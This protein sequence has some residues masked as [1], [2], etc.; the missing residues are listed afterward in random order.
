LQAPEATEGWVIIV[1][2]A[3]VGIVINTLTALLFMR[4][5]QEDLNIRG[6]FLHMAADA[7][8][9]LGVVIGG[10]LYVCRSAA[11]FR[12]EPSVERRLCQM[13][14]RQQLAGP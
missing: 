13:G 14:D 12:V 7:L 9:S 2:V 8:V 3:G 5:G 4:G 11:G 6:A 10:A 1:A